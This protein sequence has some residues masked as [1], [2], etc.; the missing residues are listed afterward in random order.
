M[1]RLIDGKGPLR[2]IGA[3]SAPGLTLRNA[4]L[5]DCKRIWQWINDPQVRSVSFSTE[6]IP[7]EHHKEWFSSALNDHNIVYY[8][9]LD[10]NSH[11]VGQARFKIEAGEAVISVLVDP[12]SRGRSRGSLL[13][14]HATEKL[15]A[16]TGIGKVKAFIK[17]GNEVSKKA[18]TR[19]GYMEH[20]LVE[21]SR[22]PAYLFIKL[23]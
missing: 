18:F 11:P 9:A 19:A 10:D 12:E 22:E 17:I 2:I 14:R 4:E 5:S 15:F 1:A 16:E 13:I 7:L 21:Y 8:I 20:G 23:R 6:L 3:M